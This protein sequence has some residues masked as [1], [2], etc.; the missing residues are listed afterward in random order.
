MKKIILILGMAVT[1]LS[2]TSCERDTTLL[3]ENPKQPETVPSNLMLATAQQQ[4]FYYTAS[5]NVNQNNYIFFTQYFAETTYTDETNYD[6]VTRNQPRNMFNRFYT[7]VLKNYSD[8]EAK[9]ETE[10][11]DEA[12]HN[13]KK[14]LLE[15]A[16]VSAWEAVVDT[17]GDVPYSE[18]FKAPEILSPKYD[19]AKSIYMDLFDRLD[20]AVAM[21]DASAASYSSDFVYGGDMSKWKKYANTLKLRLAMNLADADAATSKAMAEA[22]ISAGIIASNDDNYAM[23]FDGSQYKNPFFD[24]IIDSGRFDYVPTSGVIDYMVSKDDPRI[25]VWFNPGSKDGDNPG[26]YVGGSFGDLNP[27]PNYA[28][29]GNNIKPEIDDTQGPRYFSNA[30]NPVTLLSY[31]EAKFLQAEA[32]ARGYNVGGTA[33]TFYAEAILASMDQYNVAADDAVAYLAAVPFDAANWKKS[34][35][36]EAYISLFG[37]QAFASWNFI[38]RLDYPVLEN[39]ENSR[40][41]GVPVRMPYSDQ[42]YVLNPANV[43]AAASAIGGDEATTKLFWDKN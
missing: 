43:A 41:D 27:Y 10:A 7:R 38:R 42:E 26:Q 24:D 31:A 36:Q 8:A 14:A 3:N 21:I 6:L 13:N 34:I 23:N 32:A 9:L 22:A 35:G 28:N 1:A 20:A 4:Q 11:N 40:L 19:D 2:I 18:A 17:Y 30:T 15:I 37:D 29:P 12:V 5:P 25:P 39:P 33:A 16:S